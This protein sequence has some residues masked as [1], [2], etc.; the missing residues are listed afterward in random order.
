MRYRVSIVV[1]LFSVIISSL[2]LCLKNDQSTV[3]LP[4]CVILSN[5]IEWSRPNAVSDA[6][7][8]V[9]SNIIMRS[10][11]K[12]QA[13]SHMLKL[14][15]DFINLPYISHAPEEIG[16]AVFKYDELVL[17]IC[18][19]L[20]KCGADG[21]DIGNFI[22]AAYKKLS[23]IESYL[24]CKISEMCD[25]DS[26]EYKLA[27]NIVTSEKIAYVRYWDNIGIRFVF[28]QIGEKEKTSFLVKWNSCKPR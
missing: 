25:N 19:G 17:Y 27:G 8:S 15:R 18:L 16:M 5:N 12:E 23:Q 22:I 14:S 24:N 9:A 26:S 3:F 4:D 13:L 1:I 28:D 21:D 2:F 7:Y 20:V 10:E 11:S 6:V